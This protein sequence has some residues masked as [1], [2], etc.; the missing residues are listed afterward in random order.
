MDQSNEQ[1]GKS[2]SI[3]NCSSTLHSQVAAIWCAV[4][5]PWP[6]IRWQMSFSWRSIN[7][8]PTHPW[9]T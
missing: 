8:P 7:W 1:Y 6:W 2:T 5:K 4:Q 3:A 9:A